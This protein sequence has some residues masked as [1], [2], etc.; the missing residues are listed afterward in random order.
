MAHTADSRPTEKPDSTVVAGPVTVESAT[1]FTG[2]YFVSVKYWVRTWITDASTSPI[3]TAMPGRQLSM[4]TTEIASTA[5][6][7]MTAE[8]KNPRLIDFMPCS[9]S[10]RGVTAR[11]PTI[12]VT[13]PTART[14]SGNITPAIAPISESANAAAPRIRAATSVTS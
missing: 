12:E 1:S 13:T 8:K 10:E 5:A 7:E 3:A 9:S 11:M 2:L 14:N 4:Y 6:A